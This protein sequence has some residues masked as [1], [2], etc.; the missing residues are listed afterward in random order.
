MQEHELEDNHPAL[1]LLGSKTEWW[2]KN[3]MTRGMK[4]IGVQQGPPAKSDM[5]FQTNQM[6]VGDL[7]K[8][9][10]GKRKLY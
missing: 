9:R 8:H 3:D 1:C 5:L 2:K 4:Y 7:W 6:G 10:R